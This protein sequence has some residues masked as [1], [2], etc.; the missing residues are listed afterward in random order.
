[1]KT[2]ELKALMV[3][4]E[5][6]LNKLA[7]HFG[8][9]R[10]FKWEDILYL[11]SNQLKGI[12]KETENKKVYVFYFGS[13][14]FV[15]MVYHEI[16]DV[17]NYLKTINNNIMNNPV[18]PDYIEEY[19]IE[20][21]ENRELTINDELMVVPEMK[22]FYL[23]VAATVLAKSVALHKIEVDIDAVFDQV[24]KLIE[25]LN[26]GI[27]SIRYRQLSSL[28]ARILTFK[29]KTISYIMLLDKPDLV[30]ENA[31]AEAAFISLSNLYE[32]NERHDAI[33]HKTETLLDGAEMFSN[34]A[35]AKRGMRLELAIV[36]LIIVE[37]LISLIFE[38]LPKI[39]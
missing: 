13:I 4:N 34:L 21:D 37:I 31:N 39:I 30:W 28:Y 6:N 20:E 1:M 8:I 29:Y 3:A 38:L 15:N 25:L 5:I 33:K 27:L 10:K 18:E 19:K 7:E 12:I 16:K 23:E 2:A 14:V 24:E 35:H 22:N 17:I 26:K 11:S 9:R 32:L 36:I